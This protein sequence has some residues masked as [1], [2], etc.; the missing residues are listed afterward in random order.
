MVHVSITV[1]ITAISSDNGD[2]SRA[3]LR[4][5]IIDKEQARATKDRTWFAP[6]GFDA[7]A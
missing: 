7:A 6:F 5:I 4:T 2:A 3:A 1:L